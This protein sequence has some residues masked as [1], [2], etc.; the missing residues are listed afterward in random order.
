MILF[1]CL[2]KYMKVLQCV[3]FLVKSDKRY[4]SINDGGK[5]R[6]KKEKH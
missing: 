2:F 5:E 3:V 1:W 6:E 4:V